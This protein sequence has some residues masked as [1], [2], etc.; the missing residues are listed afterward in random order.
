MVAILLMFGMMFSENGPEIKYALYVTDKS[1]EWIVFYEN[2]NGR[3]VIQGD[4]QEF[5]RLGLDT[6]KI[7]S[8][9]ESMVYPE[10]DIQSKKEYDQRIEGELELFDHE[11][12]IEYVYIAFENN[13]IS[14]TISYF[15]NQK[16]I[17]ISGDIN[18]LE[19]LGFNKEELIREYRRKSIKFIHGEEKDQMIEY[20]E[21]LK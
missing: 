18:E 17:K 21:G 1:A 7:R 11:D 14:W 12:H 2:E 5:A 6:S 15:K 8:Y 20:L 19:R 9:Y 16:K 3:S 13:F 4:M 10:R